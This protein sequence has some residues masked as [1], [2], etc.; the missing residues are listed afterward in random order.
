M[1]RMARWVSLFVALVLA[2]PIF[3]QY[4]T[5][6]FI[7]Y[8]QNQQVAAKVAQYAEKWRKQKAIDWLGY[9]M[10]TWGKKCPLKVEV[11]PAGSSGE[12][13][14]VFHPENGSILDQ[15]MEVAGS[16]ERI[17]ESVLPHEITHTV[18]AYRFRRALPRWADEGGS[19]LSEDGP[20]RAK[21]DQLILNTLIKGNKAYRLRNLFTIM[22]YPRNLED[23]NVLYAEGYSV[24]RY[25]VESSSKVDFLN[26][27]GDAMKPNIGWDGAL[28]KHYQVSSVEELEGKWLKWIHARYVPETLLVSKKESARENNTGGGIPPARLSQNIIRGASPDEEEVRPAR[29]NMTTS[30]SEERRTE[31][32]WPAT[33]NSNNAKRTSNAEGWQP[34]RAQ[35]L[36][37]IPQ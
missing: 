16:L 34:V 18:F 7:V 33:G 28:K 22:I 26:F 4:E 23:V 36:T 31:G 8:A 32:D 24:V 5:P 10:P 11:T 37:P 13:K 17:L 35:L 2:A 21:H 19:V 20:E 25:L 1:T 15:D 27:L 6:N 29:G 3:G 9:E 14:F 30:R 12:T